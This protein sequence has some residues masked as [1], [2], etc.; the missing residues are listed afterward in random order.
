MSAFLIFFLSAAEN[1]KFPDNSDKTGEQTFS[2]AV[3][4]PAFLPDDMAAA[5]IFNC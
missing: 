4:P 3:F 5:S 1:G 2:M